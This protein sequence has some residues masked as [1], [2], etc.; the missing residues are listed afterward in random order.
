MEIRCCLSSFLKPSS[1]FLRHLAHL[2][3]SSGLILPLSSGP[4][5]LVFVLFLEN[6][7]WRLRIAISSA[8]RSLPSWCLPLIWVSAKRT[9]PER[10]RSSLDYLSQVCHPKSSTPSPCLFPLL[11]MSPFVLSWF[12]ICFLLYFLS[13]PVLVFPFIYFTIGQTTL[14]LSDINH[15]LFNYS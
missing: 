7:P 14:N 11:Y 2:S 12:F 5:M 3:D 1:G 6:V 4:A 15:P 8:L 13:P 10:E 9:P